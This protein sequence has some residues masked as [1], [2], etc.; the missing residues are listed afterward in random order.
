MSCLS[1][2]HCLPSVVALPCPIRSSSHCVCVKKLVPL[3]RQGAEMPGGKTP[4]KN[5]FWTPLVLLVWCSASLCCWVLCQALQEVR[6]FRP[7]QLKC[8]SLPPSLKSPHPLSATFLS[9]SWGEW[10]GSWVSPTISCLLCSH[11]QLITC[12]F[13]VKSPSQLSLLTDV[14]GTALL[15][16]VASCPSEVIMDALVALIVNSNGGN[17][18]IFQLVTCTIQ[19]G[20]WSDIWLQVWDCC[21][22][23]P[24]SSGFIFISFA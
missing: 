16:H 11:S 6:Y 23:L 5:A 20:Q 7:F 3:L 18:M 17:V 22:T 10:D 8:L 9:C 2:S 13:L 1:F 15:L 12:W 21:L 14:Q 4:G 24:F 19:G